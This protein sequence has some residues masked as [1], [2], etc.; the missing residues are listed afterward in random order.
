MSRI[1]SGAVLSVML[2][3]AY[4]NTQYHELVPGT[5]SYDQLDENSIFF[6]VDSP[7]LAMILRASKEE[8]KKLKKRYTVFNYDGCLA[9]LK[10][11]EVKRCGELN[12]GLVS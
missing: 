8:G 11:F 9:E 2:K 7:D 3:D 1:I 10:G 5:L 6:E 4:T 12:C